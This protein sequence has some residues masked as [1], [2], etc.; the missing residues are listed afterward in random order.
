MQTG[1]IHM[2][3]SPVQSSLPFFLSFPLLLSLLA[4]SFACSVLFKE[5]VLLIEA[6]WIG[7]DNK[8][9]KKKNKRRTGRKNKKRMKEKKKNN[10]D[11]CEMKIKDQP[12][13]S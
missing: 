12:H 11:Q 1:D 6:G 9:G 13:S 8:K 2:Q 4:H 3:S 5:I 7:L 10:D